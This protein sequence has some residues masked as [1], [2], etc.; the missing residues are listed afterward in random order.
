MKQRTV[1]LIFG[2]FLLLNQTWLSA[3]ELTWIPI[4]PSFGGNSFNASWMMSQAEIQN[5][6]TDNTSSSSYSYSQDPLDNFKESL[7]RQILSRLASQLVKTSFG[8]DSLQ[9]GHYEIGDYV[10]EVV[11][12]DGGI[13]VNIF[14]N[15]T[16]N[17][18]NII[19]PYY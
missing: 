10:I 9:P 2:I 11:P 15:G 13:N 18:T 12:G 19:V 14:D 8:E 16:G 17:Q 4:N 3:T 5:T 7:N 6:F 1:W